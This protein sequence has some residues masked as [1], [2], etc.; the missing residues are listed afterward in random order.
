[1]KRVLIYEVAI[2]EIIK[3]ILAQNLQPGDKLPTER[4]L[5]NQ[6]NISRSCIREAIQVL[7]ANYIV[8]VRQGSGIYV[9]TLDEAFLSRY[10]A[11]E[12]TEADA[13]LM[14]KNVVEIRRLI[15]TYG[16]QQAAEV[17]TSEQLHTL[18]RHE[19]NEYR[20]WLNQELTFGSM[21]FEQLLLSFQPN[22]MLTSI[23]GRLNETWKSC[24]ARLNYVPLPTESRHQDHLNIIMAVEQKN[25]VK[26]AKAVANH[27]ESTSRAIKIMVDDQ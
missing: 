8:T 19:A 25:P 18:Y 24:L 12:A 26:I 1:M 9:N 16:F 11:K 7:S 14:I 20:M 27:L 17:I 21:D 22:P 3:L 2:R 5:A 4:S 10:T 23:H 6:L 15:E 13:L